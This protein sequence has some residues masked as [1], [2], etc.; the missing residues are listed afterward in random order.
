MSI[1]SYFYR[2]FKSV[3]TLEQ[4]LD[5]NFDESTIGEAEKE[6]LKKLS[7]SVLVVTQVQRTNSYSRWEKYNKTSLKDNEASV[8]S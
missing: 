1:P 8:N 3:E 4:Y 5:I 7:S 6:Q 2:L